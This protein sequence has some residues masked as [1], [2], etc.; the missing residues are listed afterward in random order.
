MT[1]TINKLLE[2]ARRGDRT[3]I[4]RLLL[5]YDARLRRHVDRWLSADP[6]AVLSVEDVLQ[7]AY[8]EA[9]RHLGAL[10]PDGHPVFYKWLGA[11]AHEANTRRWPPSPAGSCG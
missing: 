11:A 10:E 2:R 4:R 3:A 1:T 6:R 7:E 8:A 5:L 9:Y